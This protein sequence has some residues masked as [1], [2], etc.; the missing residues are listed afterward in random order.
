MFIEET[1]PKNAH[2]ICLLLFVTF[3]L[4]ISLKFIKSLGRYED[5]YSLILAISANYSDFLLLLVAKKYISTSKAFSVF[6]QPLTI[7][8]KFSILDVSGGPGHVS[9]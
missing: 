7:V 4:K 3:F 5:F 1:V 9:E 2:R 6:F 8:I